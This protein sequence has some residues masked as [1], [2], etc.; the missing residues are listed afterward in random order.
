MVQRRPDPAGDGRA[1][2]IAGLAG[3]RRPAARRSQV[4]SERGEDE[5]HGRTGGDPPAP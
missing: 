5:S 1:G 4:E 3:L 2:P